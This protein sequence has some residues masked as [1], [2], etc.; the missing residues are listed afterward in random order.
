MNLMPVGKKG[1]GKGKTSRVAERVK[2]Q[3]LKHE[4]KV[5]KVEKYIN[6]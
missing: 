3:G 4:Q 6:I 5:E 1:N 2:N